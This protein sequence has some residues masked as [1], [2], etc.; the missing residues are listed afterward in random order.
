M[1]HTIHDLPTEE[2]PRERLI[3][4]GASSL[5]SAELLA[6]I[7]R[8]GS[9]SEN[10][11]QLAQRLLATFRGLPGLAQATLTELQTVPGIG[12]AKAVEIKAALELGRRLLAAAPE[13]RPH[14][15]TPADAANIV[16]AD[17][18][19]LEQ[20]HVRVLLL[21]TR[22]RLIKICTITIGSI[23]TT[24]FRVA[25]LFREA[26]REN[27]AGVVVF[28][29]H[30]SGDPNPSKQDYDVTDELIKSGKL[31]GISV[32]DHIVIG[33]N[34]YVSLKESGVAFPAN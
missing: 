16:M 6:I 10:V 28:H 5:G 27:A 19:F 2:R 8:T 11:L 22:Q 1:Y 23:N 15:K 20:E 18:A 31:L 12:P 3:A 13:E 4:S 21:D 7:L 14:I 25:E 32:L 34:R 29:N 24:A 9:G 30:P 33:R 17:M 26:I